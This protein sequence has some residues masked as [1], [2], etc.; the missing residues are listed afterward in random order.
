M[1][2]IGMNIL[3][4]PTLEQ[5]GLLQF[6][7]S[8]GS[9]PSVFSQHFMSGERSTDPLSPDY[10][11]S[12]FNH[13]SLSQKQ[14]LEESLNGGKILRGRVLHSFKVWELLLYHQ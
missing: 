5:S 10:V 8:S 7:I 4:N 1:V 14:K 11:P 3:K 13:V 9:L 6:I 12:I 2:F